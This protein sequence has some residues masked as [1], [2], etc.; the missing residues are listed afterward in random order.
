VRSYGLAARADRLATVLPATVAQHADLDH[1]VETGVIG[2]DTAAN[3]ALAL[4]RM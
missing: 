3:R 1:V 4:G 2:L